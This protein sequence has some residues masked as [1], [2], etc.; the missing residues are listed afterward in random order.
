MDNRNSDATRLCIGHAK[1]FF[2]D[3]VLI[4]SVQSLTR[5]V[6][7]P[8]KIG[9]SPL[10]QKD[11]P[12]EQVTYF[13]SSS[14]RV[15]RDP[16]DGIFKCWY[17][18][19]QIHQRRL[20]DL[21]FHDPCHFPSRCLFAQSRDGVHWEKP[22]LDIR[23]EG[24]CKT[25]IVMGDR[26][27]K[28]EFGSVHSGYVFLDP[29]EEAEEHRFK[30]LFNH[31]M[32]G[33]AKYQIASS[34][35][36]IHWN[37]WKDS[38]QF[39]RWGPRL[40]D[41]LTVSFDM[42]S[43]LYVLN[44]R[45]PL[46]TTSWPYPQPRARRQ[47]VAP[48]QPDN[49]TRNNKRRIF[50]A[51]SADLLNWSELEPIV[52]PDDE[53]DNLDDNFYGMSQ[54]DL[55]GTWVGFLDV[56]HNV[57]NTMDVQLLY[58]RNGRDFERVRPGQA[59]L[60]TGRTGCWDQCMVN[61]FGGP[62]PVG[63]E[64]YV[65]HGGARNHHDWWIVGMTEGLS[66]PEATDMNEVGYCLGLA[67]MRQDRF[68]S[69]SANAVREGVLVTRPFRSGGGRLILNARC[70]PDGDIKVEACQGNGTVIPGCEKDN[71]APLTGDAVTHQVS[72]KD[73]QQLPE[74]WLKLCFHMRDADLYTFQLR[75]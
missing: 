14:W 60:P 64:L 35:D 55:G 37:L 28:T 56:F 29:F 50:Q 40:G 7:S 44:T 36:G 62:V 10:I 46:M 33:R 12:W 48:Y 27:F 39:G 20:G 65:Y 41:V 18:D 5:R 53:R 51:R 42:A 72:W 25:N 58:S 75:A 11:K 47:F 19:W 30:I 61:T 38:P 69:L 31:R 66:V 71:C 70:N 34:P 16:A 13:T 1:Q 43:R 68:V 23:T 24:G 45:H 4:E 52:V 17:E 26:E 73:S 32:P 59:W 15:I 6:H 21:S 2:F 3:N 74:G 67:K 49:P 63:D 8:E 22:E 9:G 57:A 54:Y